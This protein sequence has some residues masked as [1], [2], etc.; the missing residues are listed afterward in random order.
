MWEGGFIIVNRRKI[1]SISWVEWE[2]GPTHARF[3]SLCF[4]FMQDTMCMPDYRIGIVKIP[5]ETSLMHP[6]EEVWTKLSKWM[7]EDP[8]ML[9]TGQFG[10]GNDD[11]IARVAV[12]AGAS[13]DHLI[14]VR[15]HV[16]PAAYAF[17]L[18]MHAETNRVLRDRV[19]HVLAAPG[20][21]S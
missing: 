20:V 8:V 14:R 7:R 5:D 1:D 6:E 9:V 19:K 4:S 2:A 18:F 15:I 13:V 11:G 21:S 10:K 3:G 17:S 12:A 16:A